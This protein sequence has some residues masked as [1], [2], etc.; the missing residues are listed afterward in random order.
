MAACGWVPAD[1]DGALPTTKENCCYSLFLFSLLLGAL[2]L[3]SPL[4]IAPQ[5]RTTRRRRV[6]CN[7]HPSYPGANSKS[8]RCN[9]T[10]RCFPSLSPLWPIDG[11]T[12][13]TLGP[14]QEPI[15]RHLRSLSNVII[16]CPAASMSPLASERVGKS[17]K[18]II[19]DRLWSPF[20][21]SFRSN[22]RKW[23]RPLERC[24]SAAS[25]R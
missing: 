9:S 8:P 17:D 18:R 5:L 16:H 25:T 12:R 21:V 4:H 13:S 24:S 14:A 1:S 6:C 2:C 10:R 23:N 22:D 7:P 20:F 19:E 11:P 15:G 3:F